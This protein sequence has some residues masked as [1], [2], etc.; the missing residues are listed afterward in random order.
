MG[1]MGLRLQAVTVG[2]VSL[3]SSFVERSRSR[4]PGGGVPDSKPERE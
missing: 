1:L 3:Y 2:H 4:S